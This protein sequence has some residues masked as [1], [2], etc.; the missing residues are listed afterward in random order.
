M[1]RQVVVL[2]ETACDGMAKSIRAREEQL[3]DVVVEI[4]EIQ[5]G[6]EEVLHGSQRKS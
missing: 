5:A 2:G 1:E 6:L 3:A 4:E